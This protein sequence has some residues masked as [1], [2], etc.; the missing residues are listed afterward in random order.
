MKVKKINCHVRQQDMARSKY[1]NESPETILEHVKSC[2][3]SLV[4]NCIHCNYRKFCP[5]NTPAYEKV[6]TTIYIPAEINY[7][8]NLM[9]VCNSNAIEMNKS[10]VISSYL[11]ELCKDYINFKD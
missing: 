3:N 5:K 6:R 2:R 9:M 4:D 7:A 8:F 1:T 11:Y 10:S